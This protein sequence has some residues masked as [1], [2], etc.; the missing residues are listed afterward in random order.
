MKSFLTA[1]VATVAFTKEI[2]EVSF[3]EGAKDSY[4]TAVMNGMQGVM[5]AS[6]FVEDKSARAA[7]AG[8]SAMAWME[9][10]E[11]GL[12][13]VCTRGQEC[14]DNIQL[15]TEASIVEQWETMLGSIAD[16]FESALNK[17]VRTLNAAWDE[18]AEC[19]HGCFCPTADI[20]YKILLEKQAEI[21]NIVKTLTEE[22][23]VLLDTK[24]TYL[25]ECPAFKDLILEN[26]EHVWILDSERTQA[27]VAE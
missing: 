22:R 27:A 13:R 21:Y 25:D 16:I 14:R 26:G 1:L 18:A 4:L 9:Q 3:P 11:G 5:N 8:A 23:K 20:R 17:N 10:Y 19:Y 15:A 6:S 2:N 7:D 12:P 24:V